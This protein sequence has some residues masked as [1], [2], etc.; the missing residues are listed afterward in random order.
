MM[1]MRDDGRAGPPLPEGWVWTTVGKA[2]QPVEKVQ[3]KETPEWQFTYLDISSIDN[4]AYRVTEPKTYYG[5]DAPSRARQSVKAG[6][7][8]FSTVRTYLKNVALVPE[9]YDGQIASTGFAVLRAKPVTLP[10]YL[11]YYSLTDDF[12]NALSKLQRGTSYPAVRDGD[13]RAQPIPLSPLPEQ[14]RIVEAI[15]TQFT[16]LDAAVRALERA[17]ANLGRYKASVLKAACEGRLV[18]TEA[19]L[20]PDDY[21]PAGVLLERILDERRRRWEAEQWGTEVEKAKKKAAQAARKARGLPARISD[22]ADKEWQDLPGEAYAK[23]LPKNDRWKKKYDEPEPPDTSALPELPEGW[24]WATVEQLASPEP[25]SIQSGPFGSNLLHSEFQD[26]G[27][28]AI[29]IDNVLEQQ[30][31]MGSQHRI[32]PEKFDELRKFKARPL[33]VLITVMATVGRCCVVPAN[34]ETAIITKHVYRISPN[35]S[36]IDSYY[37]MHALS[38]GSEVRRQL[39]GEVR[40]QTRPGING[41]IL[42]AIVI[43]VPPLEEQYRIVSEIDRRSSLVQTLDGVIITNLIRVERLRQAILKCAFEGRLVPQDPNDDPASVL[44]ERIKTERKSTKPGQK[45]RQPRQLELF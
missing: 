32:S 9:V 44:L 10:K 24:C 1:T 6:D 16:R 7:V 37:L 30:F 2:T 15:E 4:Q 12:L 31:S 23:Y 42:K 22:L 14:H 13:V 8:L 20:H 26:T 19:E 29:G 34:L 40:G 5:A 28:L 43:P 17:R 25:R 27:I 41:T 45:K 36:F 21:E 3:P 38:G 18:P 11:F 35:Q 33:D 39:F